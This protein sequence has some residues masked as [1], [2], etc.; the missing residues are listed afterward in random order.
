[1]SASSERRCIVSVSY[2]VYL[3][4]CIVYRG[5]YIVYRVSYIGPEWDFFLFFLSNNPIATVGLVVM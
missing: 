4:S 5:S 1:M 3:V 2:I